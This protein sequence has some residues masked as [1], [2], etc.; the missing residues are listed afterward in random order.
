MAAAAEDIRKNTWQ[1]ILIF[2]S[3]EKL[4]SSRPQKY[5]K[6]AKKNEIMINNCDLYCINKYIKK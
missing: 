5:L 3:A 4:I 2:R 6:E 1:L